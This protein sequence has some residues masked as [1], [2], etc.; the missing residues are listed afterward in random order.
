MNLKNYTE[1]RRDKDG[2]ITHLIAPDKVIVPIFSHSEIKAKCP[3]D[4]APLFHVTGYDFSHNECEICGDG[5][6]LF[7]N[8]KWLV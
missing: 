2:R 5:K 6:W 3:I 8:G 7:K 4:N 1:V